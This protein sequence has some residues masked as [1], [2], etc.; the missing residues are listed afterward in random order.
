[1]IFSGQQK[2]TD[3]FHI[4]YLYYFVTVFFALE[5]SLYVNTF[6]KLYILR[7]TLFTVK[8]YEF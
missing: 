4:L 1:M 6:L 8:V 7:F 5:N 3:L 2:L